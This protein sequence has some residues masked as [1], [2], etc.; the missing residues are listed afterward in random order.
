MINVTVGGEVVGEVVG[1]LVGVI[2]GA[3]LKVELVN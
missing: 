3:W 1:L 2:T